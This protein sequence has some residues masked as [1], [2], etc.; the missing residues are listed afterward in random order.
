MNRC[1]KQMFFD[2]L[3]QS[4]FGFFRGNHPLWLISDG[5]RLGHI[6][7]APPMVMAGSGA[8]SSNYDVTADGKRFLMINDDDQD[9]ATSKQIVVVLGW[10]DELTRME[11]SKSSQN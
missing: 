7:G 3:E 2:R 10:A 1:H 5:P 8:T 11:K 9:R 4:Q 6:H